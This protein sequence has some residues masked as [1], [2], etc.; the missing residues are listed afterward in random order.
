MLMIGNDLSVY[1]ES[2]PRRL[3]EI[4]AAALARLVP[5]LLS[6]VLPECRNVPGAFNSMAFQIIPASSSDFNLDGTLSGLQHSTLQPVQVPG[7]LS[8]ISDERF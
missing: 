7:G 2:K 5:H 6:G 1:V 3:L 4:E 8:G